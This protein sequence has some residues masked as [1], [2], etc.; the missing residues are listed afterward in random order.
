MLD[1]ST[2][3]DQEVTFAYFGPAEG[4]TQPGL[5]LQES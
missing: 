3:V 2:E 4:T 5:D 1:R